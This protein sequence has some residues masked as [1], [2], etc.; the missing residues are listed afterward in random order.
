[1][2]SS[3][4][5]PSSTNNA[6]SRHG[7][8]LLIADSDR[9]LDRMAGGIRQGTVATRSMASSMDGKPKNPFVPRRSDTLPE[10]QA[11]GTDCNHLPTQPALTNE[12]KLNAFIT[13]RHAWVTKRAFEPIKYA[14]LPSSAIVNG[15]HTIK[16]RKGCSVVKA[17]IAQWGHRET[18][19]Y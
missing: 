13:E 12:E 8:H 14:D 1:M 18:A 10:R 11:T 9:I 16:T 3:P 19:K 7:V 6:V 4:Q 2:T 15:P 17:R 5:L